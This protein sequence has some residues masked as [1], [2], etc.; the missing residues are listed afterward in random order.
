MGELRKDRSSNSG[1]AMMSWGDSLNVLG[2]LFIV[3]KMTM[4]VSAVETV[5]C[6]GEDSGLWSQTK[7]FSSTY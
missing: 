3:L 7:G 5:W 4:A 1:L 6:S 2:A